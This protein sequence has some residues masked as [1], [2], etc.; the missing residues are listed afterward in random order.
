MYRADECIDLLSWFSKE[1][2]ELRASPNVNVNLY[3][4]RSPYPTI[5]QNPTNTPPT[6]PSPSEKETFS[7]PQAHSTSSPTQPIRSQ[8][9]DI[10]KHSESSLPST[11]KEN[12]Y[13]TS[14][15]SPSSLGITIRSGRPDIPS[16]IKEVVR[17]TNNGERIAIGACGPES[18]MGAVRD[19]AAVSITIGGP[20]IELHTEQFG[21]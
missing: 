7:P 10:E 1:L 15:E 13:S 2:F 16:L 5:L 21:W 12:T 14:W 6:P 9:A 20:S 19:T 4:T 11:A 8:E 18:L 17:N 3:S